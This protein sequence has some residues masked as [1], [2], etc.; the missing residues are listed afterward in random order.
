LCQMIPYGLNTL[1]NLPLVTHEGDSEDCKVLNG[2]VDY[3]IYGADPRASEKVRVSS[4]VDGFQP[5]VNGVIDGGPI[6][7]SQL[8]QGL[9]GPD[10][11]I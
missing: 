2:Q 8:A 3:L 1:D 10:E 9:W 5:F 7:W 11:C 6:A 4:H